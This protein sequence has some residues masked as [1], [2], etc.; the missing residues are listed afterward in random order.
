MV[1]RWWRRWFGQSGERAAAKYLRKLGYRIVARGA[2][3]R[4]G[5]VDLIALDR[6]T[7]VFVEVKTRQSDRFG[8]PFE[9]VTPHKQRQLT[10]AAAA[11]LKSRNLLHARARFDV[12][13]I[14]WPSGGA[15]E[16]THYR[17]AF[18]SAE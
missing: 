2:R 14:V 11:W 17:N 7:V 8:A 9:S 1:P 10:R 5:E 12:V 18:S 4:W 16:I 15:P 3:S 13:A 6:D